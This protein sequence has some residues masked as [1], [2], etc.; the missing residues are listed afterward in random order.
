MYEEKEAPEK[1]RDMRFG[2][3]IKSIPTGE[4]DT[5]RHQ[6]ISKCKITNQI[7]TH[8]K[9]GNTKVPPLAQ[10]IINE[11]AGRNIFEESEQ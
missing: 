8:W 5:I 7:F 6:I 9:L 4:Y 1:P 2:N 10:P 3:Y 11:I